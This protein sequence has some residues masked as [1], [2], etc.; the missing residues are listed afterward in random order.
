MT[1]TV[2]VDDHLRLSASRQRCNDLE[3][4]EEAIIR[5]RDKYPDKFSNLPERWKRIREYEEKQVH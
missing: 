3:N 1:I 5:L 2:C 4:L